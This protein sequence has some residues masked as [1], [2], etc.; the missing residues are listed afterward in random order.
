MGG[1]TGLGRGQEN[2]TATTIYEGPTRANS[3]YTGR[4]G[5]S[6]E[7]VVATRRG[8]FCSLEAR[9]L[10]FFAIAK[11]QHWM[12]AL[13]VAETA[14]FTSFLKT[15]RQQKGLFREPAQGKLAAAGL[16]AH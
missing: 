11:A 6:K 13:T 10:Y 14:A 12:V 2:H 8:A 7:V 5:T 1:G 15:K 4:L 3:F 9:G 16:R